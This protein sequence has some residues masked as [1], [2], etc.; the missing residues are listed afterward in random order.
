LPAF[1]YGD[2]KIGGWENTVN[3]AKSNHGPSWRMVVQMSK[4]TEAYGV[5]PGGQSG[6][7]GSKYYASFLQSW[8]AGKYYHLLFLPNSAQQNNSKLKYTWTLQP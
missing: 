1:S 2:L 7:P 5:Y 3:A 6:N 8:V 4:N